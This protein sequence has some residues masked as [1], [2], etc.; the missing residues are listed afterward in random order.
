MSDDCTL[1]CGLDNGIAGINLTFLSLFFFLLLPLVIHKIDFAGVCNFE[2]P[3]P[4]TTAN[5]SSLPTYLFLLFFI[6]LFRFS[7]FFFGFFSFFLFFFFF[8][9]LF[10]MKISSGTAY[11]STPHAHL[12]GNAS[13]K[14]VCLIILHLKNF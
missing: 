5:P 12:C 1:A 6:I 7:G 8:F 4:L 14:F 2:K 10:L 13:V 11:S 9:F 3:P